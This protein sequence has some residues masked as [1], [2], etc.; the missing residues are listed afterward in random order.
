MLMC[1]ICIARRLLSTFSHDAMRILCLSLAGSW[2]RAE[3]E[4]GQLHSALY[5][6]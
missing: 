3:W 5:A 6:M 1:K 2:W 4:T